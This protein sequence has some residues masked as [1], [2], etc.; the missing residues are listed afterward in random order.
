MNNSEII[1]TKGLRIEI[2]GIK[3]TIEQV[4]EKKETYYADN[5]IYH[6]EVFYEI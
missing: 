3:G 5:I 6:K 2:K 4:S 1:D